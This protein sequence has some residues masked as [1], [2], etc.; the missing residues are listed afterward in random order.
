MEP[1]VHSPPYADSEFIFAF[2]GNKENVLDYPMNSPIKH[3]TA[4]LIKQH[5]STRSHVK[6]E[7][8]HIERIEPQ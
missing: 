4:G 8:H 2:V 5:R 7:N 6:Q 3:L 1:S